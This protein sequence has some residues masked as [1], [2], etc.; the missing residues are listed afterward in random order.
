MKD[1]QKN[2]LYAAEDHPWEPTMQTV[3]EAQAY[4]NKVL[5]RSYLRKR[6]DLPS[7]IT[8]LDGR[9]RRSGCADWVAGVG[10]VIRLPKWTRSEQVILHEIAHHVGGTYLGG[11]HG[12]TYA[13]VYLDLVGHMLGRDEAA[14][15]QAR[16]R[17][18]G[19]KIL[20][21]GGKPRLPQI[22]P[23]LKDYAATLKADLRDQKASLALWKAWKAGFFDA[24]NNG[25]EFDCFDC[26]EWGRTW[27]EVSHA[28]S[29]SDE[30]RWGM[31]CPNGHETDLF[32]R[33]RKAG[34]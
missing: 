2:R 15:M 18:H 19:V 27:M 14:K 17:V 30:V 24:A 20:D 25:D 13:A 21:S 16:F 8:V 33:V 32:K 9:M 23:A 10:P 31:T 12:P 34:R 29:D 5:G 7:E 6:Y 22:P 3:A 1:P 11:H 4:V 28:A 26:G